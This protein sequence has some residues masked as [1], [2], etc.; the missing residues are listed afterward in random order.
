MVDGTPMRRSAAAN[1]MMIGVAVMWSSC[2]ST[3][4]FLLKGFHLLHVARGIVILA[5]ACSMSR[6]S[7]C[8][9]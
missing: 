8:W 3:F 1:T 6:R 4:Y 7:R 5:V 2:A 9:C